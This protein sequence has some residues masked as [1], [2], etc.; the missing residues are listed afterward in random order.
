MTEHSCSHWIGAL[1]LLAALTLWPPLPAA[2]QQRFRVHGYVQW[3][4]GNRMVVAT[5]D[6]QSIAVDLTRADQ[7]S[8]R[9]VLNGDGVTVTGVIVRPNN[10][11]TAWVELVA[12]SIRPD[13]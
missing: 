12:E 11:I 2:A 1:L 8:Y 6:G 9:G 7:S 10:S 13:R 4:S 5:D 3:I